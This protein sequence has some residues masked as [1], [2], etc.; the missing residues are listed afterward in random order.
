MSWRI[1]ADGKPFGQTNCREVRRYHKA[2][3]DG[4]MSVCLECK[5]AIYSVHRDGVKIWRHY[6]GTFWDGR[7]RS[8]T[9]SVRYG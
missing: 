6:P 5:E 1:M 7:K 8:F 4:G 9:V 3:S 2:Q